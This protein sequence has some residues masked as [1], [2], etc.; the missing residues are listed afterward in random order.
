M[1]SGIATA[2]AID[3]AAKVSK[4]L[5]AHQSHWRVVFILPNAESRHRRRQRTPTLKRECS[6]Y[7]D[8]SNARRVAAVAWLDWLGDFMNGSTRL[9]ADR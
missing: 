1:Q 5:P 4:S 6:Y 7:R 8:R 3:T 2:N 9:R